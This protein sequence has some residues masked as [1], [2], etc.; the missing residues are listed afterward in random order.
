MNFAVLPS[1]NATLNAF[2]AVFLCLGFY[3]IKRKKTKPH[4]ICMLAAVVC[5]VLFLISY[6]VYHAHHGISRFPNVGIKRT[7]YLVILTSHTILAVTVLPLIILTLRPALKAQYERHRN[8]ARRALPIWLY[9]S[10]TGVVIYFML[11][12]FSS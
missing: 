3:F 1:I 4:T 5:S 6:I 11:Y 12:H 9:V 7:I 10:I 8:I 2:S